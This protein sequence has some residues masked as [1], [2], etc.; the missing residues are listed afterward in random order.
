MALNLSQANE[1]PLNDVPDTVLKRILARLSIQDLCKVCRVCVKF[2]RLALD[3]NALWI[4]LANRDN[5]HEQAIAAAKIP[6]DYIWL[7]LKRSLYTRSLPL[8][9][10]ISSAEEH[11]QDG[12]VASLLQS[13]HRACRIDG[14]TITDGQDANLLLVVLGQRGN[15]QQLRQQIRSQQEPAMFVAVALN[16][17]L[18]QDAE[19]LAKLC[20]EQGW[21][22]LI[23]RDGVL[24]S[25]P[26]AQPWQTVLDHIYSQPCPST[27]SDHKTITRRIHQRSRQ[28]SRTQQ[29]A[30]SPPL[31]RMTEHSLW[32]YLK[33]M[34]HWVVLIV[35]LV[36]TL[37]QLPALLFKQ[38]ETAVEPGYRPR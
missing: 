37:L 2:R 13:F 20:R 15:M 14:Y 33:L 7:T 30:D 3:D 9:R 12:Q 8:P 35:A 26:G 24:S 4:R 27:T 19:Q 18:K 22:P 17:E 32:K 25:Y 38:T 34:R 11:A 28:P 6:S 29:H 21:R 1:Y 10:V 16:Q 36:I 5:W 31:A 23:D